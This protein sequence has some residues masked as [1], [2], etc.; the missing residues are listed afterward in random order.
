VADQS[1][2]VVIVSYNARD[3]LEACLASFVGRTE[4][5]PV[6]VTVVDNASTDGTPAMLRAKWPV[7]QLIEAG[8]NVGF[9]RANN[10]G[11]RATT[12]EFVLLLN[13]DTLVRP[14]SLQ[15]LVSTL[16]KR[17]DAA[18]AGPRLVDAR[19]FPELSFGWTISPFGELRQKVIGG[20]LARNVA[21][22]VKMVDRW[23]REPGERE[24]VSGA[25]LLARRSDLEAIGLFDERFFMYTE[26]VDLCVRLRARGRKVLFVPEAEIVHLR[27]TS[28]RRNPATEALR[29]RSQVAY[30]EKHHPRWAPVLKAYLRARGRDTR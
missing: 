7:V 17:P 3:E 22:V 29:R 15:T 27:G 14:G 25:A 26:D 4:P 19:G 9:S 2:A 8:D 6:T 13:P 5:L 30:Y 12:S 1:I 20:L 10:I 18:A 11:I 28:A 24:W 21:P 16:A 23:T